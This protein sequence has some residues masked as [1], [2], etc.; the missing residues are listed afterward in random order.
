MTDEISRRKVLIGSPLVVTAAALGAN[1]ASGETTKRIATAADL[2][3]IT[4]MPVALQQQFS[5]NQ[6]LLSGTRYAEFFDG[7]LSV[8]ASLA[9][10]LRHGPLPSNLTLTPS[11]EDINRLFDPGRFPDAGYALLDGPTAYAQSRIEMP[12]V[13]SEM[14]KWWFLW[15]PLDKQRYMLWFPHAH[16]ENS[17]ED[18]KRLADASLSYEKRLYNNPNHLTEF[19]GPSSLPIIIHFTDPVDLGFDPAV[20]KRAGITANASGTIR[21]AAAP[22][23]TFILMV[24]LARDT[25]RGLELFSRY[26]IGAHPEFKRF[27]GGSNAS[28]LLD[29]MGMGKEAIES[30]AY[31]M[32]MHDLTEFN[33]LKRILPR[34]HKAFAA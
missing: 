15:H 25:N 10:A 14:F 19:I 29:K 20:L 2:T 9:R 8:P 33:V 6:Q 1:S 28:G 16:V 5:K 7:D 27:A 30:M 18:P 11:V 4:Y 17:V 22:D 32:A 12:G 34:V 26:W 21:P 3:P 23:T 24:H 13:T 31:E